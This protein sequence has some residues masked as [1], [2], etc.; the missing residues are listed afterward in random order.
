MTS[1]EEAV[2]L[3]TRQ[4]RALAQDINEHYQKAKARHESSNDK[5]ATISMRKVYR[6]QVH[7]AKLL[8]AII[9]LNELT[10]KSLDKDLDKQVQEI[11]K[12]QEDYNDDGIEIPDDE[13]LLARLMEGAT[14]HNK[15]ARRASMTNPA[16]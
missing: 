4:E 7:Q 1:V 10:K 3:L 9:H 2:E 16:A 6:L 13:A 11:L 8:A 14:Q 12:Q 5:G 15:M